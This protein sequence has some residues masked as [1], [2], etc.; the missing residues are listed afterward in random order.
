MVPS[1]YNVALDY[2]PSPT[3]STDFISLEI[4]WLTKVVIRINTIENNISMI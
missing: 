1:L 2:N 4:K 3:L